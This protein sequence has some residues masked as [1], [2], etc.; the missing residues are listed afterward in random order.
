L[1]DR[2][3]GTRPNYPGL[4]GADQFITGADGNTYV[5]MVDQVSLW[6]VSA[7]KLVVAPP[8]PWDARRYA[9]GVPRD[10][11]VAS[12]GMLW[13]LYFSRDED[14]NFIWV[15]AEGEVLLQQ[16][17]QQRAARVIAIDGENVAYVCGSSPALP[18]A[19]CRAISPNSDQ[20][21]WVLE[22]P[23]STA[24]S[25]GALGNNRLYVTSGSNMYVIG[26]P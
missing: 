19:E 10:S 25:G 8:I 24:I 14:A 18:A 4:A 13:L 17:F 1:V 23:D 26:D 7:D 15:S 11:G 20:P 16:R 21:L 22:L 2:R 3:Q 12:N 6:A 5:R 9:F